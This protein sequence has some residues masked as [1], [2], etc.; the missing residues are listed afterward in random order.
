MLVM[1]ICKPL[2]IGVSKWPTV[3]VISSE[4]VFMAEVVLGLNYN[5]FSLFL[6]CGKQIF[7]NILFIPHENPSVGWLPSWKLSKSIKICLFVWASWPVQHSNADSTSVWIWDGTF[8]LADQWK[9]WGLSRKLVWKSL[10]KCIYACMQL[11]VVTLLAQKWHTTALSLLSR[12]RLKCC[13]NSDM[14][15]ECKPK[16]TQ[17]K[18]HFTDC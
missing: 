5:F 18:T 2:W 17:C 6:F 15:F 12:M 11:H 1:F 7:V 13:H 9:T 10:F 16:T 4:H 8:C 3:S 14:L